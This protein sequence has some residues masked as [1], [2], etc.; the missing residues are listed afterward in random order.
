MTVL[1]D[2]MEEGLVDPFQEL[3]R[4]NPGIISNFRFSPCILTVSHFYYPTNALNY[5]NLR[6]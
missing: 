1:N 6:D 5:L 2:K 3:L 4:G